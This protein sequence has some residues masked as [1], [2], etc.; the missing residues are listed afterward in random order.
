MAV[1][2]MWF[3]APRVGLEPTRSNRQGIDNK[4]LTENENPVL[5]TGLDKIVQKYPEI[6]KLIQ[7]WPKLPETI[8]SAIVAIVRSSNDKGGA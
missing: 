5:S 7:A 4:E 8:R 3:T 6:V 1:N 2:P